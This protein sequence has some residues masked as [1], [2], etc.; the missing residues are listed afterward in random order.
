MFTS[1]SMR[2]NSATVPSTIDARS[3]ST[4]TSTRSA[5]ARAPV[6]RT[7]SAVSPIE[8]GAS[9]VDCSLRAATTMSAPCAASSSAIALPMPRDAPVTIATFS[10]SSEG[11]SVIV[12]LLVVPD[13]V[14]ET[15]RAAVPREGRERAGRSTRVGRAMLARSAS[16]AK[17]DAVGVELKKDSIDLGI[18]VRDG[19]A[20]LKF[21][22]DTL[23]FEHVADMPMPGGGGTMHRLMCGTSLIKVIE[24]EETPEPKPEPGGIASASGYRYWT[25]SISNLDELTQACEAAG[26]KLAVPPRE[27]RPGV[28]IAMVE[29][30][31][32]NWV[33]LLESA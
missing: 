29:D 32:G 27:I 14:R 24:Y 6:A 20:A 25:I 4:V 16:G 7:A 33:E 21:Y 9:S 15:V 18:V 5:S 13:V 22:R 26:Y 17:G 11:A 1:T 19:E 12:L 23:G 2:P 8:P 10:L 30:P 28:R 31:D 3:A